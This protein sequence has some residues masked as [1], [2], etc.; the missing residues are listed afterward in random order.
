[1]FPSVTARFDLLIRIALVAPALATA[2]SCG[3]PAPA[4]VPQAAP[5]PSLASHRGAGHAPTDAARG[6]ARAAGETRAVASEARPVETVASL[7]F[8][9]DALMNLHHA[10]YAAA[11]AQRPVIGRSRMLAG[12]LASPLEA[13]LTAEER[14]TWTAAV[15]YYETHL[16]AR[17]LLFGDGMVAVKT[18]LVAGNLASGDVVPELRAVLIGALPI[19]KRHFWPAHDR[20]NRDWIA[21]TVAGVRYVAPAVTPALEK[22]YGASWFTT[23]VRVDVVWVGNWAGGYTSDGPPPH[24]TISSTHKGNLGWSAVEIVFHEV[25]HVLILPIQMKI[26]RALGERRRAHRDLWHAVQFYVT[27]AVVQNA[28]KAR[29]VDYVPYMYTNG[30]FDRAWARYRGAIE[31][32]WRPYVAGAIALDQAIGGTVKMLESP[33]AP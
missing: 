12:R 27:G 2:S 16:A 11:W 33:Q 22:L 25:S 14:A 23:P 4:E 20:V 17:D 32:N 13:P 15:D 8:H 7:A 31:T 1:M 30:L 26:E 6:E 10:L 24:V 9:S 28:L 3:T 5:R 18:A 19:Y 29:G 21:A